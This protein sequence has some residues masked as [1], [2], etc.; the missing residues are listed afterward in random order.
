MP[1]CSPPMGYFLCLEPLSF[2][3]P[4]HGPLLGTSPD[5]WPLTFTALHGSASPYFA[6][7]RVRSPT[8][9]G[10]TAEGKGSSPGPS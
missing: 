10:Q 1:S 7:T 5:P 8:G 6:G 2:Q 9:E 3:I 4:A